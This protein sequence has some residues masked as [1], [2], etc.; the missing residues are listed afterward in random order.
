[1]NHSGHRFVLGV[2]VLAVGAAGCGSA[3]STQTSASTG[4]T[5]SVAELEPPSFI[6]GQNQGGAEDELNAIFAPLTKFNAQNQL[7][8]VQAQSVTPSDGGVVWTIKIKPSWTFHNGEPVTAQSYVNAWN[9]TAYGPNAWANNGEF[10][11]FAGYP[12]LNPAKGKPTTTTLSGLKA[13]D[14]TTIQVRLVRPVRLAQPAD[15]RRR[16]AERA[17][18]DPP[19]P[20]RPRGPPGACP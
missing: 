16:G 5:F 13:L 17:A 15:D 19:R 8:Y 9:A 20:V 11:D 2:I 12:A 18:G 7:T 14:A 3:A 1:M 10:A 6:P 4:G